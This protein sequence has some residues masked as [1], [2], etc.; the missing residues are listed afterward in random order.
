MQ[1]KRILKQS[2]SLL[3]T[4]YVQLD[5]RWNY[6]NVISPYHR[7]Y[8]IDDGEGTIEDTE[9]T[10]TLE[11]G[12]LYIIPSYTLCNLACESFLSQFFVQFFEESSDGTSIFGNAHF[13]Y[14][15]AAR[16]IDIIN[17]RR[18]I[19]LNPDRG[20]DRSDNPEIYEKH[21]YYEKYQSLNDLQSHSDFIETQGILLQLIS[22]FS[23]PEQY[24]QK[25]PD[26]PVK[27]L[28]AV[29]FITINFHRELSVRLLADRYNCNPQYFSRLFEQH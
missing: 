14:K 4:D 11:A 27:M 21:S 19:E 1:A 5:L 8:F 20:L 12:Y 10:L 18:L 3:N 29:R 15:V 6:K 23:M 28:D 9:K 22:R 24:Y 2:I 16:E 17:F 7:I 26:I 13:V 25:R